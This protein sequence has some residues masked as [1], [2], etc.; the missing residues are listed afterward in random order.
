MWH[1]ACAPASP[2]PSPEHPRSWERSWARTSVELPAHKAQL[3]PTSRQHRCVCVKSGE[4]SKCVWL[5]LGGPVQASSWILEPAGRSTATNCQHSCPAGKHT[6][7]LFHLLQLVEAYLHR[8]VQT[9]DI[10]RSNERLSLRGGPRH[11]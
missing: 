3:R 11:R 1:S 7:D 9:S 8:R 6:L 10:H 2:G 4:A 5:V